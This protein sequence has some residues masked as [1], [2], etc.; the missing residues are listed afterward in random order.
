[1]LACANKKICLVQLSFIRHSSDGTIFA[2]RVRICG[3]P[4]PIDNPSTAYVKEVNY[5]YPQEMRRTLQ[6]NSI[7]NSP[8]QFANLSFPRIDLDLATSLEK[9]EYI[10]AS[11]QECAEFISYFVKPSAKVINIENSIHSMNGYT[12]DTTDIG[13]Q[14][15]TSDNSNN[16]NNNNGNTNF[17]GL[18]EDMRDI[19]LGSNTANFST[20]FGFVPSSPAQ[21]TT[22]Q[23]HQQHQQSGISYSTTAPPSTQHQQQQSSN[24]GGQNIKN[25]QIQSYISS[26]YV[27]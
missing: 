20:T 11:N 7:R 12:A 5:P 24:Y 6:Q 26:T 21:K 18:D 4:L 8:L 23:Q 15:T 16:A 25:P 3:F 1:M 14:T 10:I 17:F 19:Q 27:Q 9:F 22:S 2:K 13:Y